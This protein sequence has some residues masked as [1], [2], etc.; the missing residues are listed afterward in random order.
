MAIIHEQTFDI[1]P[2]PTPLSLPH[3]SLSIYYPA[4][5]IG[6]KRHI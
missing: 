5:D 2:T 1:S 3:P 6:H 4:A